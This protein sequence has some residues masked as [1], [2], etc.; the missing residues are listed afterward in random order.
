MYVFGE[1]INIETK[2]FVTPKKDRAFHRLVQQILNKYIEQRSLESPVMLDLNN[3]KQIMNQ[4][5]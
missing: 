1:L 3:W 5:W 2:I 4:F